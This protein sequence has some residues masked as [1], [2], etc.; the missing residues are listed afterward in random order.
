MRLHVP[1]TNRHK[2]TH[3]QTLLAA[4]RFVFFVPCAGSL[5]VEL[6]YKLYLSRCAGGVTKYLTKRTAGQDQVSIRHC[7]RRRIGNVLSF[8]AN[9]Q[10]FRFVKPEP[11][12]HGQIEIEER[13][14]IKE[15]SSNV[16]R[17]T[18]SRYEEL[19]ALLSSEEDVLT[20]LRRH[21]SKTG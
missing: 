8:D 3:K 2:E 10:I 12:A 13:W 9:F 16:A 5:K 17:F 7:K 19:R 14:T 21:T 20:V 15:V 6:R 4:V 18:R 11:L 1:D